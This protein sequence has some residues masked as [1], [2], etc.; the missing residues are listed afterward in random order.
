[1]RLSYINVRRKKS[2]PTMEQAKFLVEA[3]R[4]GTAD[5]R[6][7]PRARS[8]TRGA[9]EYYSKLICDPLIRSAAIPRGAFFKIFIDFFP[10]YLR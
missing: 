8:R 10:S 2:V 6:G 1:M 3:L 5:T 9:I 4:N 7:L